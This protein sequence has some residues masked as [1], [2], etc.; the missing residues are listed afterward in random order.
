WGRCRVSLGRRGSAEGKVT[1][2]GARYVYTEEV[3]EVKPD[4]RP[5][6]ARRVYKAAERTEDG[7]K[8][9]EVFQNKTV[10]IDK[11]F[12]MYQFRIEGGGPITGP[13][14][15]HLLRTYK[16]GPSSGNSNRELL[17]ERPVEVGESW[18]FDKKAMPSL[19][20]DNRDLKIDPD[21]TTATGR[22]RRVYRKDGRLFGVILIGVS[23]AVKDASFT[24][25]AKLKPGAKLTA[26]LTLD[27]CI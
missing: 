23:F 27:A 11:P 1:K 9:T 24:P 20:G 6:K 10:L 19:F 26:D 16:D 15:K 21:K 3:I 7:K 25:G 18:N 13:S 5:T 4:E 22:L 14:A 2:E 12:G 17:P 8:V